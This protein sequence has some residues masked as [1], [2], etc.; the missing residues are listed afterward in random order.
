VPDLY[1]TKE[2]FRETFCADLPVDI[3]DALGAV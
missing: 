2:R 3:A 1:I